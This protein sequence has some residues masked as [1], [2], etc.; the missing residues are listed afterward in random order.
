MR[1]KKLFSTMFLVASMLLIGNAFASIEKDKP[2]EERTEYSKS[3]TEV[4]FVAVPAT[5]EHAPIVSNPEK[6]WN[7][8]KSEAITTVDYLAAGLEG[9]LSNRVTLSEGSGL[10]STTTSNDKEPTLHLDPGL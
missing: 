3:F 9:R 4:E 10:N 1:M 8:E 2:I 6:F 5:V 7:F